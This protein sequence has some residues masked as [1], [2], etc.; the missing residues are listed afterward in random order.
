MSFVLFKKLLSY[1]YAIRNFF[2]QQFF[3]VGSYFRWIDPTCN[4]TN[5][6]ETQNKGAAFCDL[7][8]VLPILSEIQ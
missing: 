4:I 7:I 1:L 3:W 6:D 5:M 8:L 2:F